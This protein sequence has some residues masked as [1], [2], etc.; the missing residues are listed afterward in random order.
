MPY[1]LPLMKLSTL[2]RHFCSHA[3]GATA[4][5]F[6]IALLPV[7]TAVGAAIDYTRANAVRASLQAAL[8]AGVLAG[9]QTGSS[10]WSDTALK[11]FNGNL[12]AKGMTAST[13][14]FS[15]DTSSG[16]YTGSVSKLV[17]TSVL[18][19][20]NIMTLNVQVKAVALAGE[21]DHSCILT[22]DKGQ[23]T[24][25]VSLNL[26]GAPIINLSGCSIR[27][28]TALD[29]NGHDGDVTKAIAAGIAAGC[30]HPQSNSLAVPDTY[31]SLAS[32]ITPQCG[33]SKPGVNWAGG[34][35]PPAGVI[36][37]SNGGFT[38]Y[39]VCGDLNLSGTGFLTG[40]APATDALIVVENGSINIGNN[41]SISTKRTGIV[42]TGDNS[43]TSQVNF[44]N[45]NGKSAALTL[46]PPTDPT[47]PW[48]G[49]ALFQDPKLTNNVNNKWGPGAEFNADGLVYLGN[50]NVVTDGNTSSSNAKCSKFVM[51]QF[52]TNGSVDLNI[53]QSIAACA[54]IGLKQW[55]GIPVRLI[56]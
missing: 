22:L 27:S 37:V 15:A 3:S 39:H 17:T 2:V 10:S 46:S 54:E 32:N 13:P 26:N 14:V 34:G 24:S 8:D 9:A 55:G 19:M 53:D 52:T 43:S 21:P 25:H 49:V 51:N 16:T 50:S 18:G 41:A 12:T 28:N 1:A 11:V 29:C 4:P 45:G 30:G 38:E 47:N 40:S 7:V 35:A 5:M 20:V 36:T 23:P 33:G 44:P 56:K 31:A 6:A 42:M 48:Q